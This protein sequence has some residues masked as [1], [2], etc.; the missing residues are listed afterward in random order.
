MESKVK[1]EIAFIFKA[2]NVR[3][4][5]GSKTGN[6]EGA[7]QPLSTCTSEDRK[8]QTGKSK[9]ATQITKSHDVCMQNIQFGVLQ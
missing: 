5:V 1:N 4:G 7:A 8:V 6:A 3:K 2:N 9:L